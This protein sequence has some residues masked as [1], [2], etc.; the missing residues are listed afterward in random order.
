MTLGDRLRDVVTG[1]TGIAISRIHYLNGCE[2]YQLAPEQLEDGK[3]VEPEWFDIQRLEVAAPAAFTPA[4][5]LA[6][7][8][9][10]TPDEKRPQWS[11]P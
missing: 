10:P 5:R 1:F 3:V 2:Q 8:G 7:V 4:N 6:A 9:G 11:R